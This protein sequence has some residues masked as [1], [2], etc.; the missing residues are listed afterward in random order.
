MAVAFVLGTIIVVIDN[1]FPKA[2]PYTPSPTALGIALTMPGS[3]G[4]AMFLGALI[5][6]V[7]EK[8]AAKLH[9][10]YTIPVA[11]GCIAGESIMGVIIAVN[12]A[13]RS[14]LGIM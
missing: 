2:K 4:L 1:V 13:V 12:T 9:E 11:S 8:K 10:M 14:A 3:Q 6:W 7:L 5:A